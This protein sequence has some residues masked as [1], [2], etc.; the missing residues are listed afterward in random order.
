M[1]S[2][3]WVGGDDSP[4]APEDVGVHPQWHEPNEMI[5]GEDWEPGEPLYGVCSGGFSRQLFQLIPDPI[6]CWW[7]MYWCHDC[8]VVW[9]EYE[10]DGERAAKKVSP[11]CWMCGKQVRHPDDAKEHEYRS[12]RATDSQWLS[13]E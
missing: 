6:A 8:D 9:G 10:W 7:G 2:V 13:H 1:H 11:N 5:A 3:D 4:L 12:R